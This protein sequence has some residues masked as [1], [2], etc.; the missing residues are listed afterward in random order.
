MLDFAQ[1]GILEEYF[2]M[3]SWSEFENENGRWDEK[4]KNKIE[5]QNKLVVY[6]QPFDIS[7][8]GV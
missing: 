5:E 2:E 3:V 4:E 8:N 7:K 6:C 1:L